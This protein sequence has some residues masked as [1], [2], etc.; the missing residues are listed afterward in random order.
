MLGVEASQR[1]DLQDAQIIF[2]NE[3]MRAEYEQQLDRTCKLIPSS[4]LC[5]GHWVLLY[6][7]LVVIM[8]PLF[9]S[10]A[11]VVAA[12]PN[13]VYVMTDDQDVELGG[14]TPMKQ[15]R[16]LLGE[17]GAVGESFYIATPICCP[18][19][20][21]TL[22]GRLYHN[23]L[24]DN[25]RGCMHVDQ[26]KYIFEH[27]SSLFPQMQSAGYLTGGFGKVRLSS[28]RWRQMRGEREERRLLLHR[29][30]PAC[31]NLSNRTLAR[32][33]RALSLSLTHTHTPVTDH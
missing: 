23:V 16:E 18:S 3:E 21:E 9:I 8:V 5:L 30:P 15:V 20:T 6:F 27:S 13:I 11:V 7:H 2:E 22:S 26:T 14:M 29:F 24:T 12:K 4:G 33:T 32:H 17:Q 19:R 25:L 31:A 1:T 10:A 28:H